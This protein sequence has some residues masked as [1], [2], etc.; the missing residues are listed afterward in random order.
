M[1][2]MTLAEIITAVDG[3]FGFPS[4]DYIYSIS[5][6]TRTIEEGS[7]FIALKGEKLDGHDYGKKAIEKQ[8]LP[9]EQ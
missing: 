3:S 1:E 2:K 9:K 7:L 5:T 6:D 8:S 4:D